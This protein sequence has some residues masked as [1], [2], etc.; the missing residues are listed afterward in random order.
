MKTEVKKL[1]RYGLTAV[2]V[3]LV[4]HYWETCITLLKGIWGAALPLVLGGVI[5]YIVNIV[6]TLFEKKLFPKSKNKIWQRYKRPVCML[7]AFGCVTVI[8]VLLVRLI[9]P[10]F[11]GSVLLLVEK[12]PPAMQKLWLFLEEKLQLSESFP[13]IAQQL[14]S[15]DVKKAVSDVLNV[16]TKGFGGAVDLLVAAAGTLVSGIVTLFLALVFSIYLLSGKEN[17]S[18]QLRRLMK[19]YIKP[20]HVRHIEYVADTLN[21]S[22]RNYIVGQSTEAV[23]L[24][25][26]CMVGMLILRLP[27]AAMVGALI[28]VTAL[29]PVAGAYIGAGLGAFMIFTVS[30][31]QAL[32]FLI[33]LLILQQLEGNLIFPRVVGSSIGLPGIWVL[34]AVTVFGGLFGIL[35]MLL[36]VPLAA[37]VYQILWHDVKIREDG[38]E[39]VWEETGEEK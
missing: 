35:G 11:V 33:F 38:G 22:F 20:A 32:V 17:L 14:E 9:L 29:I 18:V 24:G 26:L 36:G 8:V 27:Y 3:W 19:A 7:L 5:A 21:R 31:P 15:L 37:T 34:S 23:I 2:G 16:V 30:P 1:L 10:E 4:I 28:S 12:L 13:Q 6:M 25:G 39:G